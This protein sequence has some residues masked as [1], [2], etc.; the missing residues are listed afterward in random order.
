MSQGHDTAATC[1]ADGKWGN[2]YCIYRLNS[3]IPKF[4]VSGFKFFQIVS[5][6]LA[7]LNSML[8]RWQTEPAF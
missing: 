6:T 1:G 4:S 8:N 3:P 2:H 7:V 5:V